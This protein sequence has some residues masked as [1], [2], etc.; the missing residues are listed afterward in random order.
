MRDEG[1][2]LVVGVQLSK[3][4]MHR[5]DAIPLPSLT[6][7]LLALLSI[8]LD[9]LGIKLNPTVAEHRLCYSQLPLKLCVTL[10]CF[11]VPLSLYRLMLALDLFTL[12]HPS[13]RPGYPCS[14]TFGLG[15]DHS[16][17]PSHRRTRT[18]RGG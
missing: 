9:K 13:T 5:H 14:T 18:R 16:S 17:C 7:I 12:W 10:A 8:R 2:L 4:V 15:Y 11:S 1:G 6:L 3:R